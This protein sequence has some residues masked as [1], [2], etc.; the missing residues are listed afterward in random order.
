MSLNVGQDAGDTAHELGKHGYS[1]ELG[2]HGE[3]GKLG[4]L[5]TRERETPQHP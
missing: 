2:E 4:E 3:L 1:E 5:E